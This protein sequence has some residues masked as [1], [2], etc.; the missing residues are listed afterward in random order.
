VTI[1]QERGI[2][3]EFSGALNGRKFDDS[4]THGLSHCM[5]AVDFIVELPDQILFVEVKDPP[6]PA[7]LPPHV[8]ADYVKGLLSG[9]EDADF[10][11]KYR[12]SF[13]YEWAA[14]R[15]DK[16]IYYLV[17][18][19]FDRL[20][21]ADLLAR[22]DALKRKLPVNQTAPA[23]WQRSLVAGCSVFNLAAWNKALPAFPAQ[24]V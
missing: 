21:V 16:P 20:T 5:K 14:N 17:L 7:S 12:D 10:C 13:L 11:Y 4:K 18:V 9:A 3:I 19:A 6:D 23:D 2:H 22:T 8:K 1:L 15:T 24:R